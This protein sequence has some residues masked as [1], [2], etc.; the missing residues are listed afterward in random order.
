MGQDIPGVVRRAITLSRVLGLLAA[1]AVAAILSMTVANIV[2]SRQD[3]TEVNARTTE[4]VVQFVSLE[5]ADDMSMLNLMLGEI[6]AVVTDRLSSMSE[7]E[8]RHWLKT[9]ADQS[10]EIDALGATDAQGRI[11]MVS[12]D[13]LPPDFSLADR[14]Y[15]LAHKDK[16]HTSFFVGMP[17]RNRVTGQPGLPVSMGRYTPDGTFKGIVFGILRQSYLDG[18]MGGSNLGSDGTISLWRKD[19]VLL[20]RRKVSGG[21]EDTA[22]KSISPA[23]LQRMQSESYGTF[24]AAIPPGSPV[25]RHTFSHVGD[26]PLIVSA[27][28]PVSEIYLTWSHRA[29]GMVVVTGLACSAIIVLTFLFRREL[30]LRAK[31][32]AQLNDLARVDGLT[33]IANRRRF[34][35][36]LAQEWRRAYRNHQSIALLM[37]DVDHFKPFNDTYG[38]WTGDDLLIQIAQTI[39]GAVQ[40]PGDLVARYGGEEFSV[41]LP[42]TEHEGA[43]WI[44]ERILHAVREL[45]FKDSTGQVLP[46]TVSIGACAMRPTPGH[47]VADLIR[48]ADAAL[49]EAKDRGRNRVFMA[50]ETPRVLRPVAE[51]S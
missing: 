10:R 3:A 13:R 21:L 25:R 32:E 39:S 51:A 9:R 4:N 44:A 20:L 6:G 22:G 18:L 27:S 24:D 49:Y 45:S 8:I 11:L 7:D 41:I 47:Q 5:L 1:A 2:L 19:G 15:F 29:L 30:L 38:H 42:E 14:D 26:A 16:H 43:R 48:W 34:D 40:R 23:Y 31:T 35:E 17:M 12:Q 50:P 36:R 37:V 28:R 33:G 46:I